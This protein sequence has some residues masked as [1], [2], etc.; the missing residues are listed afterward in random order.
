[1]KNVR[2][3]MMVITCMALLGAMQVMAVTYE[4]QKPLK[5]YSHP[6]PVMT[7]TAPTA[8][9]QS[10]SSLPT[11]GSVYTTTPALNENGTV[12]EEAY[13]VGRRNVSGP[14]RVGGP[15]SVGNEDDEGGGGSGLNQESQNDNSENGSPIG[16]A[17]LPLLLCAL[18]FCGVLYMRKRKAQA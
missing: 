7:A 2:H 1:M 4:P 5:R 17:V 18:A 6:M 12:N 11:S 16:D 15:G 10:T 9:F 8:T 13:G 3:L 14:R